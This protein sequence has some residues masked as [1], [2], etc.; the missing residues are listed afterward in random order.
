MKYKWRVT[1]LAEYGGWLQWGRYRTRREA[2]A[3][4]KTASKNAY[5]VRIRKIVSRDAVEAKG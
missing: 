5:P 2:R 4:A 3:D 1:V